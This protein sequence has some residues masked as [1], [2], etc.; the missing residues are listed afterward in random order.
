MVFF[1]LLAGSYCLASS[2]HSYIRYQNIMNNNIDKQNKLFKIIG[3]VKAIELFGYEKSID[4][5]ICIDVRNS[6]IPIGI[7]ISDKEVKFFSKIGN[8]YFNYEIIKENGISKFI[9]NS[10]ILTDILSK[11]NISDTHINI[12]LP[13]KIIQYNFNNGVFLLNKYASSNK[14]NIAIHYAMKKRYPLTFFTLFCIFIKGIVIN[15]VLLK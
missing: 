14:K 13:I 10:K 5:P 8:K 3:N 7:R 9:N 1:S 6:N 11:Y 15:L 2:I 12:S 4:F